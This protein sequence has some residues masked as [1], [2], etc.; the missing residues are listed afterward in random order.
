MMNVFDRLTA[1][2]NKH[3][4]LI[5]S[6]SGLAPNSSILASFMQAW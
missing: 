4:W 1:L 3:T 5:S 2:G 6:W